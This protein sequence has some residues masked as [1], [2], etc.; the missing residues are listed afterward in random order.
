MVAG[1]FKA[2]P[3][4]RAVDE[5]ERAQIPLCVASMGNHGGGGCRLSTLLDQGAMLTIYKKRL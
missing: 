4:S 1:A 5:A 3:P 2:G